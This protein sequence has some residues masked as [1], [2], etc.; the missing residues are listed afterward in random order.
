MYA[1]SIMSL[2][3]KGAVEVRR[4]N[5][6]KSNVHLGLSREI[7]IKIFSMLLRL[8]MIEVLVSNLVNLFTQI[9]GRNIFGS[10]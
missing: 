3:L 1:E 10:V 7:Q 4:G 6:L 8:T 9:V 2:S 5:E